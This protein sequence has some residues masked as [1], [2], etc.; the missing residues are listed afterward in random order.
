MELDQP[1]PLHTPP[2]HS[3]HTDTTE[4]TRG[5]VAQ[6]QSFLSPLTLKE[7][8]E[9]SSSE[10]IEIERRVRRLKTGE[11]ESSLLSSL[12]LSLCLS[13]VGSKGKGKKTEEGK[14]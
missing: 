11:E 5:W 1:L 13:A 9:Q 12:A 4:S 2:H 8:R 3:C 14:S 6:Q 7:K 10:S